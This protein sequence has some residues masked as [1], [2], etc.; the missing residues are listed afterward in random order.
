MQKV[1]VSWIGNAD[2]KGLTAQSREA[3]EPTGP[4]SE[5]LSADTYDQRCLLH[6]HSRAKAKSL[7]KTLEARFPAQI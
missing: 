5:I 6:I 2:L 4:L 3:S 7:V 1:L